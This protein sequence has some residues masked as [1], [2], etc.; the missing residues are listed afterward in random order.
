MKPVAKNWPCLDSIKDVCL[1]HRSS[2]QM[3]LP[4]RPTF[5]AIIIPKPLYTSLYCQ[6]QL[7]WPRTLLY[8]KGH[9]RMALNM[10][11]LTPP[12]IVLSQIPPLPGIA[13][14]INGFP[15]NFVQKSSAMANQ[16][17][18]YIMEPKKGGR[19]PLQN[20]LT[21]SLRYT[22]WAVFT[23]V[24]SLLKCS[25]WACILVLIVSVG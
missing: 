4:S 2:I 15:S 23:R 20:P 17:E 18:R 13:V 22:S 8:S 12:A 21:P 6:S 3:K 10:P 14:V 7:V 11:A 24:L 5:L 25:F 16:L 19:A 1:L 9:S